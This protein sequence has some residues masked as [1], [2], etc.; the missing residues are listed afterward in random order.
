MITSITYFHFEMYTWYLN[1][2]PIHVKDHVESVLN[3]GELTVM[4]DSIHK[5]LK[6]LLI[7]VLYNDDM[8]ENYRKIRNYCLEHGPN[9]KTDGDI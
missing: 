6:D 9:Y 4:T 7:T 3:F 1:D 5:Q 2:V 8:F